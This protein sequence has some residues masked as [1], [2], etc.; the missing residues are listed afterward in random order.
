MK[1]AQHNSW[2]ARCIAATTSS[3]SDFDEDVKTVPNIRPMMLLA[4]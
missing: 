1:Y 3:D 4:A 2:C